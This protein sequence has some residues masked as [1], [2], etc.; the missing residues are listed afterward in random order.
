MAVEL[1][2]KRNST[3]GTVPSTSSLE[4]G[5]LAI[6]TYDGKLFIKKN[7]GTDSI[8]TFDP[9]ASALAVQEKN[10]NGIVANSTVLNVDT[11]SFDQEA[12]FDVTDLGN[13][14]VKISINSFFKYWHIDG[15]A[16]P[17]LT[18][19]GV[20]S[21]NLVAGN[22]ITITADP[23]ASPL[24]ALTIA[25]PPKTVQLFQKG[26]LENTIGEIR[27][28]APG[29]ITV[30]DVVL[31]L[32]TAANVNITATI[33]KSGSTA[34]TVTCNA[35]TVKQTKSTNFTMTTDDYLTI[36]IGASGNANGRDASIEIF[37]TFD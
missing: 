3:T 1:L 18:A 36:D 35:S 26:F 14:E 31:R 5:E 23:N 37:Y 13:G 21:L 32:G 9:S 29:D 22:G 11:L 7:D 15:S 4:L 33:K 30:D 19:E 34:E 2:H 28:Y 25:T 16:S 6:N 27:W 8:V 17:A 20:D 24:K 10:T 12:G